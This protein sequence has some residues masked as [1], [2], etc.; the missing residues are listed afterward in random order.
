MRL[1][2][3]FQCRPIGCGNFGRSLVGLDTL[4]DSPSPR[5]V[6]IKHWD[7]GP[8]VFIPTLITAHAAML[9]K[10]LE[11]NILGFGPVNPIL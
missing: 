7:T 1:N 6:S 8:I 2:S 9:L 3:H 11:A 4:G 5:D 10:I